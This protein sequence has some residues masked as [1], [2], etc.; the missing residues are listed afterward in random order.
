MYLYDSVH[1]YECD[2][3]HEGMSKVIRNIR[4]ALCFYHVKYTLN[5]HSVVA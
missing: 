1:L 3:A 4:S 5:L 2:Q